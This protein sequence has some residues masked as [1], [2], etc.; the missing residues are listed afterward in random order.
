MELRTSFNKQYQETYL[1]IESYVHRS[2][3]LAEGS[4]EIDELGV[5]LAAQKIV[6]I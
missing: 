6:R 3:I 4:S 5:H 2:A 1:G